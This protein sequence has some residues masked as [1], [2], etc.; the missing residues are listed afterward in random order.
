MGV[1]RAG[2]SRSGDRESNM[3]A[4]MRY[5][6]EETN[7]NKRLKLGQSFLITVSPTLPSWRKL[8]VYFTFIGV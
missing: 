3:I 5:T 7:G 8:K 2:G 1:G 6:S 4:E